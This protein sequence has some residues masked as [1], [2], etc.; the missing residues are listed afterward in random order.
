MGS[1]SEDSISQNRLRSREDEPR[2]RRCELTEITATPNL[3]LP[4]APRLEAHMGKISMCD[5]VLDPRGQPS[6]VFGRQLDPHPR[7]RDP[8]AM[9]NPQFQRIDTLQ[10]ISLAPRLDSL[11]GKT[12]YLVDVG[13][14]GG[15]EFFEEVS[16]WFSRNA[17]LVRTVLR[18]KKG[19]IY[20]D[21]PALWCEIR[22][23]GHAAVVGVGG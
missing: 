8:L 12:I 10:R 21:D 15:Y 23:Q 20:L 5:T 18:R 11:H 14:G 22:E 2:E 13:F 9:L 4:V 16:D 7:A 19:N 6:G 1:P 3:L 17:P